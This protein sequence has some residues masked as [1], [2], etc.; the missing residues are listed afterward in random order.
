MWRIFFLRFSE[1]M[2]SLLKVCNNKT[3]SPLS[4]VVVVFIVYCLLHEMLI[5]IRVASFHSECLEKSKLFFCLLSWPCEFHFSFF[6]SLGPND[7]LSFTFRQ[8]TLHPTMMIELKTAGSGFNSLFSYSFSVFRIFSPFFIRAF[9]YHVYLRCMRCWLSWPFFWST[10]PN[11]QKSSRHTWFRCCFMFA[12]CSFRIWY[13]FFF[14]ILITVERA[15]S[16]DSKLFWLRALTKTN[17]LALT[18]C[19]EEK[20]YNSGT[21]WK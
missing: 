20:W 17:G 6:S 19:L 11:T 21:E 8:T 18:K 12:I 7:F 1:G 9:T 10:L 16:I 15:I 13:L 3:V 5:L 4:S 2:R 14:F